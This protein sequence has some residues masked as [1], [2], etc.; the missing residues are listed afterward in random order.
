[1][2][3]HFTNPII[4]TMERCK[5]IFNS[6]T[7]HN[8]HIAI[9]R[10]LQIIQYDSDFISSD[11]SRHAVKVMTTIKEKN[12]MLLKDMRFSQRQL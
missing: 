2:H 9:I 7:E 11:D 1:M 6:K 8:I 12:H 4:F 10:G 5:L 3:R